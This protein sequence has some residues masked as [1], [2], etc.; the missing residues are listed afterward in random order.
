M[1]SADLLLIFNL[2]VIESLL[3]VDNAAVLAV[4]V[5]ELPEKQ[6]PL[7]LRLGL[8]GAYGF[9]FG[10]IFCI[11][12]LVHLYYLKIIGGLFLLYLVYKHFRA[13]EEA[14]KTSK[15]KKVYKFAA[16]LGINQFYSTIIA[17]E[18]MDL[19][20]SIDNIF[21]A[22]ALTE[23]KTVIAIGLAI[24]MISMRFVAG[25]FEKLIRK[26]PA[27][28]N[29]AFIIIAIL[30]IKLIISGC[31]HYIKSMQPIERVIEGHGFDIWF[32]IGVLLIFFI[33]IFKSKLIGSRG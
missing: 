6:R 32:S 23:N 3:S 13:K 29:S 11:G 17:V 8:I 14:D 5:R 19:V 1:T 4:L 28:E 18:A 30:G 25:G 15:G 9:R 22:S 27:L 24:G 21:A 10:L 2:I 31:C 33:P 16:S 7:A 12:F 20:F 26:Y